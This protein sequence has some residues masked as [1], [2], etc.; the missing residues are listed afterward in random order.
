MFQE[1][2][3]KKEAVQPKEFTPSQ[4]TVKKMPMDVLL[5][6]G[7]RSQAGLRCKKN[8]KAKKSRATSPIEYVG[9]S[10]SMKHTRFELQNLKK[11]T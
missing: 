6:E 4:P 7:R 5:A 8:G 1:G 9:K 3:G 10:Q 11:M 2:G